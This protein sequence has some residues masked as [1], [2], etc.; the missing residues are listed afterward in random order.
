MDNPARSLFWFTSVTVNDEIEQDDSH[1]AEN[2]HC[3]Y[4]GMIGDHGVGRWEEGGWVGGEDGRMREGEQERREG[5]RGREE[6]T[7]VA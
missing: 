7:V 2:D 6:G 1:Y 5:G 4:P 3:I